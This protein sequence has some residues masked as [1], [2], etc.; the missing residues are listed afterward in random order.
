MS[1]FNDRVAVQRRVIQLVNRKAWKNEEL[2]GLATKAI[3]R[4]ALVNSIDPASRLVALLRLTA[5]RLN[6]LAA[7]SQ[8]QITADY[9][10]ITSEVEGLAQAIEAEIG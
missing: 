7:K 2:C 5:R 6:S 10:A 1:E 4:W 8:D 3:D 9:S